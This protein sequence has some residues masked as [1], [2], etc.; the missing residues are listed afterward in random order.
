MKDSCEFMKNKLLISILLGLVLLFAGCTSQKADLS[1]AALVQACADTDGGNIVGTKGTTTAAG[2]S[3]TDACTAAGLLT[4]YYCSNNKLTSIAGKCPAGQTCQ[5]GACGRV[6][7][8]DSDG[9]INSNVRGEVSTSFNGGAPVRAGVD[10]CNDGTSVTEQYCNGN[11]RASSIISCG[12]GNVCENGACVAAPIQCVDSDNGANLAVAGTV[13]VGNVVSRD[14]CVPNIPRVVNEFTCVNNAARAT[15]IP[16][17]AGFA[18]SNGACIAET[19]T[20]TPYIDGVR[21]VSSVTGE[22]NYE[23][24]R[25]NRCDPEAT[26]S[27]TYSCDANNQAVATNTECAQGEACIWNSNTRQTACTAVTCEATENGVR[28]PYNNSEFV[29]D[30]TYTYSCTPLGN[31]AQIM[32]FRYQPCARGTVCRNNVCVASL[33]ACTDTDGGQNLAVA[34]TTTTTN[35][36]GEVNGTYTDECGGGAGSISERVCQG[37]ISRTEFLRCAAGQMCSNGACVPQAPVQN[38]SG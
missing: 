30:C 10:A 9:G 18:C 17:A 15:T 34:G 31:G 25:Y 2:V 23:L 14:A 37:T 13:T 38:E 19:F 33:A 12:A 21:F 5:N 22:P 6:T 1:G 29:N 7:C 27:T 11:A 3:R 32:E 24:T 35:P 28:I 4:E 8:S 16:C 26:V 20:C 36:N